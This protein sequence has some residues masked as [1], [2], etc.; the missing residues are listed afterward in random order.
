M[1]KGQGKAEER[2]DEYGKGEK[3]KENVGRGERKRETKRFNNDNKIKRGKERTTSTSTT[4][5]SMEQ[6]KI[7]KTK[8]KCITDRLLSGVSLI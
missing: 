7:M 6:Q 3:K 1:R 5:A 2:V 4:L 8:E